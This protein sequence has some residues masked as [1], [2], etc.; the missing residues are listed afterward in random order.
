MSTD[1]TTQ[2]SIELKKLVIQNQAKI[3]TYQLNCGS[4]QYCELCWQNLP[5]TCFRNN[6]KHNGVTYYS[7]RCL[8]CIKG[9]SP[10][11]IIEHKGIYGMR[12]NDIRP[13][14]LHDYENGATLYHL[15]KKYKIAHTTIWQWDKKGYLP[16]RTILMPTY[17]EI[18]PTVSP[19][20]DEAATGTS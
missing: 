7:K 17:P 11:R 3:S 9:G 18:N 4:T 6:G 12:Y 16:T 15:S 20:K 10:S 13:Y 5:L 8:M 2:T 14:F 1:Q 19:A